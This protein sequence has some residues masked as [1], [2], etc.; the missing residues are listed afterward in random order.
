MKHKF[1]FLA[2]LISLLAFPLS[3]KADGVH[4]DFSAVSPTG[5]ILYYRILDNNA[6]VEVT[7]PYY[8][9]G[10]YYPTGYEGPSGNISIP[11]QVNSNGISYSV[12]S[13][14]SQ[15]FRNC[16]Y[17]TS[18]TLPNSVTSI[19]TSTFNGC[20]S[21]TSVTIPN[22]VTSIG[23]RAFY[24]CS[25]LT[26]ATISN[27]VISIGSLAFSD[28]T[29][30]T[31]VAIPNSVTSIGSGT[32][33]NCRSLTSVTIPRSVSFIDSY[34]F[35]GCTRLTKII[36]RG[37][38]APFCDLSA[39]GSSFKN[40]HSTILVYVPCG[41]KDSYQSRWTCFSNFMEISPYILNVLSVDE[42]KG[43]ARIRTMPACEN[44]MAL[45]EATANHGYHFTQWND[46]D[47]STSR[48]ILMT[49]DTTFTAFFAPNQYTLT[50]TAG[51][52][53]T[54]SGSGG[55]YNY[56]D[57]IIIQAYPEMNYRFTRWSD[58]V[59][60]NPRTIVV[61]GN[62]S[63]TANFA[64]LTFCITANSNNNT[65]GNVTGSGYYAINS[66]V[67]LQARPNSG[68]AFARW[69]DG[70]NAN[71]RTIIATADT[72]VTAI[73]EAA[74]I[75]TANSNNDLMGSVIGGGQYLRNTEVT[76]QAIPRN[77]YRFVRWDDGVTTNPRTITVT[78]DISLTAIF[79][80]DNVTVIVNRNDALMGSVTGGGNYLRNSEVTLQATPNRGYHFVRWSDN[81]TDNPRT[82]T[83]SGD[84]T[85]TAYFEAI[86]IT[87][88]VNSNDDMMGSVSGGGWFEAHTELTLQAIPNN[89]YRFVRWNDNVTD[90]PRTVTPFSDTTFTAYFAADENAG[91]DGVETLNA[92]IYTSNGQIVVDG[93]ERNTVWL[94]DATGR[95]L[96]TK[97]NDYSLLRFSVPTSGTY[98][99]KIGKRPAQKVVVT[100]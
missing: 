16:T 3:I 13:I 31:S 14:G 46:G 35:A 10:D 50:V 32:F 5:Q 72:T 56:G 23:N 66:E 41:S 86:T 93:T 73:F 97:Q 43:S 82:L 51:E 12:T 100:K 78:D 99:V 7:Y 91:I 2:I 77:G 68:Y 18:V 63:L 70:V 76:L 4:Y 69:S 52:H 98:F 37:S 11:A 81:I 42:A 75:V 60:T 65:M 45:I 79:E 84:T 55:T 74:V 36:C 34:A 26:S 29:G 19:G 22:S 90:N 20:S 89:G 8:S 87:L 28:C 30:L 9:D 64:L 88:T 96:S 62:D 94:Y 92:M 54:V 17:L 38:I 1:V 40:V 33:M 15:A 67:T 21:L 59:T 61:S 47:I 44:N 39:T 48:T 58:G 6:N 80:L 95:L 57:T 83:V 71:P 49:Q 85:L 25:G 27:S 53:G 24:G